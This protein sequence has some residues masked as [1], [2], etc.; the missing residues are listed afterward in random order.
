M[1]N[2]TDK[3]KFYAIAVFVLQVLVLVV[4]QFI[5]KQ[6]FS[7]VA[8]I[9]TLVDAIG[10]GY[11]IYAYEREKKERMISVSR[12]LGT[13]AK[14]ALNHGQIGIVIY[15]DDYEATWASELFDESLGGN[16]G[17][18]SNGFFDGEFVISF[19]GQMFYY[20]G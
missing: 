14:N 1:E 8:A 4:L 18:L 15:N 10:V 12:I 7:L 5:F 20:N 19:S 9:F 16:H 3:I 2:N 17:T 13:E 11:I 6:P